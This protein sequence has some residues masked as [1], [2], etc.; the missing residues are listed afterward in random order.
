MVK[1]AINFSYA[2]GKDGRFHQDGKVIYFKKG[3]TIPAGIVPRIAYLNP[4][5][6]DGSYDDKVRTKIVDDALKETNSLIKEKV[7]EPKQ[8]AYTKEQIKEWTKA[9]QVEALAGFGLTGPEITLL[10]LESMRVDKLY[11]LYMEEL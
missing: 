11:Q 7:I 6:I 10:R 2:I 9:E 5:L 1:A 3:D 8:S 4:E